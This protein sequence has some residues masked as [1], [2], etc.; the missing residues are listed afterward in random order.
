MIKDVSNKGLGAFANRD[1]ARGEII[2]SER[3]LVIWP[4]KLTAEQ[5]NASLA[6]LTPSARKLYFSLADASDSSSEMDKALAIRATNGFNVELPAL[7]SGLTPAGLLSPE[8]RPSSASFIFP[9]IARI[10]HSCVANCDHALNWPSGTLKMEVYATTP[11][12]P[13]EEI[14]IEYTPGLVQRTRAERQSMLQR[15]FGFECRCR[16]CSESEEKI[17]RSDSRRREVDAI[18]R[19]LAGGG[20]DRQAMWAALERIEGLLEAEGYK[21]MPEFTEQRISDAYVGY[22]TIKQQRAADV[23]V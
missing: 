12:S 23:Q 6:S 21:A 20:M 9:R 13:G 8:Q 5:A 11:I 18:V 15:D 22:K 16:I 1:I 19:A 7:T 10:N 2:L 4:V 14:S 17:A 3:P